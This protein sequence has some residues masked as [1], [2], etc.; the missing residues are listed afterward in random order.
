VCLSS[1]V[2]FTVVL[3]CRPT[4]TVGVDFTYCVTCIEICLT[5]T[6]K[7]FLLSK[8]VQFCMP[9]CKTATW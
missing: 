3:P 9:L 1:I 7:K 8:I 4:S 5:L 2:G 6:D